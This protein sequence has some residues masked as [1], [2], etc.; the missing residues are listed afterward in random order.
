MFTIYY[1]QN[2]FNFLIINFNNL[3]SSIQ[4]LNYI[5]KYLTI[6]DKKDISRNY[7]L[8]FNSFIEKEEEKCTNKK[9]CLKKYLVSL[10]KGINSKFL[11]LQYA[12]K[13]FKIA[14][15]KF[16]EDIILKINY[17]IFL[18]TKINKKKEAKTELFLIK[19]T[20]FAFND[21]FYLY[22]CKKYIEDFFIL[23]T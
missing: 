22:I 16:P 18:Y 20:F 19:P 7:Q 4:C 21:N 9:C 1:N 17:A 8:I 23:N 15:S 5:K 3:S 13:L 12:E 14:I 10:S 6:I 2:Y 11:L